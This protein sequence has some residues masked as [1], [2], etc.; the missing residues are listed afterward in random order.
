MMMEFWKLCLTGG[1]SIRIH[2]RAD[3]E[4]RILVVNG[5]RGLGE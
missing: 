4:S 5:E 1:G 2:L 3:R